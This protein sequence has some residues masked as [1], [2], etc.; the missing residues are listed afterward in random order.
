MNQQ[1]N[2]SDAPA[3]RRKSREE[4][5][6]EEIGHTTISRGAKWFLVVFF[7]AAIAL[8]PL[9]QIVLDV[10]AHENGTRESALPGGID[11]VREVR[12]AT[13]DNSATTTAAKV[14]WFGHLLDR[15]RKVMGALH[16]HED[17]LADDSW[18]SN[19][20]LSP[21]QTFFADSL[22]VGNEEA[23]VGRNGML[24][25]R[26]DMEHLWGR[27]FLDDSALRA[28]RAAGT[29][30]KPAAQPDPLP[31]ILLLAR[32]LRARGIELVVVPTP[33]KASICSEQFSRRA[34]FP[35]RPALNASYTQFTN[36]L[37]NPALFIDGRLQTFPEVARDPAWRSYGEAY[38]NLVAARDELVAH[39]PAVFD[40]A[41]LL[42]AARDSGGAPLYL[43]GDT[44]W[45]PQGMELVA[46]NLALKVRS[47]LPEATA[48]AAPQA[49][50]QRVA[51]TNVGD[52]AKMLKTPEGHR[53][54]QPE[55]A[56]I[57][58][59]VPPVSTATAPARVLLLGDSFSNIYSQEGL[60]WGTNA[61]LAEQLSL[62]LGESV[63]RIA[64][65]AGGA[66]AARS[67]LARRVARHATGS[68][69]DPLANV[70][71]VVY[72]FA[73]RELSSGDWKLI[74]MAAG[75]AG[76]AVAEKPQTQAVANVDRFVV[77]GT[78]A[79]LT[80]PPAP[81][82]VPY[83]DAVVNVHLTGLR[84]DGAKP[85]DAPEEILLYTWGMRK[86]VWCKV[87][88]MKAGDELTLEITPWES[89]MDNYGSYN[90][91]DFE[92]FDLLMLPGFWG[93]P[94]NEGK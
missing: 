17:A 68:G 32:D 40:A 92:D 10:R 11:L 72:Q 83:E 78:I 25:Y 75:N 67:E 93:E 52:T 55:V 94:K 20:A 16:S 59:V 49:L 69:P 13:A 79:D 42:V 9:A 86:R 85:D 91:T 44:H 26:T 64:I 37:A 29:E 4:I 24:F 57:R 74:E 35:G 88:K 90:R 56:M 58:Q 19:L 23:F 47:L 43:K 62:E 46:S 76:A 70:K 77:T 81:E 48:H 60:G 15:N 28:R 41:A 21:M 5:A 87:A 31:A 61:G 51:I 38:T 30:W 65:N 1:K 22:G 27:G 36:E 89:V 33:L 39:P 50:A 54:R 80:H 71:V 12:M 66:Y 82:S 73:M 45:T 84:W 2:N 8:V 6:R 63:A 14:S 34:V 18:I 53:L 7:L 3:K